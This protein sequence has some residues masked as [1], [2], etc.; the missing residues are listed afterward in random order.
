M[1][2][3]RYLVGHVAFGGYTSVQPKGDGIDDRPTG[4][5]VSNQGGKGAGWPETERPTPRPASRF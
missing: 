3:V 4:H 5:L 1:I 2:V